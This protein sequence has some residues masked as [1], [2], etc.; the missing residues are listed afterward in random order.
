[1]DRAP[2]IAQA[3]GEIGPSVDADLP[4]VARWAK[5]TLD[6]GKA[7][8]RRGGAGTLLAVASFAVALLARWL[9]DPV[10]PAGFPFLTFFPAVLVSALLG[11]VYPGVLCALL[12]GLAAWLWFIPPFGRLSLDSASIAAMAFYGLIVAVNVGLIAMLTGVADSLDGERL[13]LAHGLKR[14]RE[15]FSELQHRVGN[16]LSLISALFGLQRRK[17]KNNRDASTAF[18]EARFRI[19]A[20]G[21]VHRRLFDPAN[22]RAPVASHLKDLADFLI[23]RSGAQQVAVQI[24]APPP[25]AINRSRLMTLSLALTE[26]LGLALRRAEGRRI[27]GAITIALRPLDEGMG[28]LT[29]ID[30]NPAETEAGKDDEDDEVAARLIQRFAEALDGEV[31]TGQVG[32]D[33]TTRID[34]R[35][36]E[37]EAA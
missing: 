32:R 21:R 28:R 31:S 35:L 8:R 2:D 14:Q 5:R 6:F 18:D 37:A 27:G 16:N 25:L 34:F 26:I 15:L 36:G 9:A 12:S 13:K 10:L 24:D 30:A 20:M 17:L 1:M 23:L 29:V 3:N 22:E 4:W 11:G 19:D 7:L 33:M